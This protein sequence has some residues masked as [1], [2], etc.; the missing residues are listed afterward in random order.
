M[1]N[2]IIVVARIAKDT[3]TYHLIRHGF[4][5]RPLWRSYYSSHE[6]ITA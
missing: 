4:N 1:T 3:I 2:K 5:G 6:P